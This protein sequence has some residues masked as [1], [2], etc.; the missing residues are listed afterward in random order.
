MHSEDITS[1][2]GMAHMQISIVPNLPHLRFAEAV[3][4]DRARSDLARGLNPVISCS[5]DA[6]NYSTLESWTPTTS[7]REDKRCATCHEIAM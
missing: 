1:G 5:G 6:P 3:F 2:F 7:E 4:L